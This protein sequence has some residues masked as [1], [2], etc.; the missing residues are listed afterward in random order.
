MIYGVSYQ[1]ELEDFE[2]IVYSITIFLPE[3]SLDL[4]EFCFPPKA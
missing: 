1:D 2:Y 4:W 3:R